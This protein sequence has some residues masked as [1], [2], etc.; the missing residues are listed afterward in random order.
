MFSARDGPGALFPNLLENILRQIL[1]NV[2]ALRLGRESHRGYSVLVLGDKPTL[3][4]VPSGE[5]L[6]GGGSADETRVGYSG[7][8]HTG[9]MARG[10]VDAY[11]ELMVRRNGTAFTARLIPLKSQMALHALLLNSR[12]EKRV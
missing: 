6:R 3:A 11:I 7:E 1:S 4:L 10:S 5:Q 8:A 2:G 12:A 9:N